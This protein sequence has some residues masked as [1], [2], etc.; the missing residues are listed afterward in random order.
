[1]YPVPLLGG[2]KLGMSKFVQLTINGP[3]KRTSVERRQYYKPERVFENTQRLVEQARSEGEKSDFLTFVPD[4]EPTLDVNL[5]REIEM[6]RQLDIPIAVITNSSL[7]WQPEVRDALQR[8]DLV[9]LKLDAVSENVWKK[10]D[11]PHNSLSLKKI[12]DGIKK[13]S[14]DYGGSILT[15]TMLIDGF[16]HSD[17]ID[18]IADFLTNINVEKAYIAIP[19]RPPA[20]SWV[21]PTSEDVLNY[22]YHTFGDNIGREKVEFL[23]E[24][25]GASFFI[26]GN[27][28]ED[29]LSI[30][31]VHPIRED[32]VRELVE[33]KGGTWDI[34]ERMIQEKK[35]VELQYDGN[36]YYMRRI[37]SRIR[38]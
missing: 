14:D 35:L 20:E 34:I 19:T 24:Y 38:M 17:E 2:L 10:I 8:A 23:I 11:Q 36:I 5:R 13:F 4:G 18:R 30:A 3:T 29:L 12:L 31:S 6:I 22:A 26:T 7:I 16:N 33:N 1:M 32:A 37:P 28:E 9:S 21:R 25:E 27:L 15:E